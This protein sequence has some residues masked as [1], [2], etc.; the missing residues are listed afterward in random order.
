MLL[1]A[2]DRTRFFL[3]KAPAGRSGSACMQYLHEDGFYTR[4]EAKRPVGWSM[5]SAADS[6]RMG[7]SW[8]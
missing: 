2:M 8:N 7:A 6:G 1:T 5:N 3:H 4:R